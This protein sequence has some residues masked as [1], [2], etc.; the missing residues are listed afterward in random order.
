PAEGAG[1]ERDRERLRVAG[2]ELCE[3]GRE[4]A[5]RDAVR[6]ERE[7]RDLAPPTHGAAVYVAAS[8]SRSSAWAARAPSMAALM[9]PPA[10]PAPSPTGY[11]FAK[12]CARSVSG[13][14]GMRTG[15][16]LR[17]SMPTSSPSGP[18]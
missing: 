9:I 13:S 4:R 5:A 14:R 7:A 3:G 18:A 16:E 11:R 12:P 2:G 8:P 17:D 6:R 10:L 15:P 1:E